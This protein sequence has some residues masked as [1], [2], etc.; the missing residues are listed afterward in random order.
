MKI[1]HKILI[2]YIKRAIRK[3]QIK[4]ITFDEGTKKLVSDS[5]GTLRGRKCYGCGTRLNQNNWAG[6]IYGHYVCN[7]LPCILT[8]EYGKANNGTNEDS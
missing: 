3:G 7:A 5:L 2:A 4:Q 8:A 1:R 6:R